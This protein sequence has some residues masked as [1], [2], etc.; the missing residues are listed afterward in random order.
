MNK[1]INLEKD[2]IN[3]ER[4]KHYKY[5]TN[6]NWQEFSNYDLVINVDKFGVEKCAEKIKHFIEN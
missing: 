5:Y 6:R 1:K 4:A 2:K 3:K